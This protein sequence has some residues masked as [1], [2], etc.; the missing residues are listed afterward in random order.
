MTCLSFRNEAAPYYGALSDGD[1]STIRQEDHS[2]GGSSFSTTFREVRDEHH[3]PILEARSK[4]GVQDNAKKE[5]Q[6][7]PNG[8]AKRRN[9]KE[10]EYLRSE[11]KARTHAPLNGKHDGKRN[12]V[13]E[14]RNA[15]EERE[16]SGSGITAEA[17]EGGE[18]GEAPCGI[19]L[20]LSHQGASTRR[21]ISFQSDKREKKVEDR[22]RSK[23]TKRMSNSVN[24][25]KSVCEGT[26]SLSSSLL[27]VAMAFP[28]KR[29][30]KRMDSTPQGGMWSAPNSC[31]ERVMH[32]DIE[33]DVLS[34]DLLCEG[35][36][37]SSI[38]TDTQELLRLDPFG[39]SALEEMREEE[40]SG[41]AFSFSSE[42]TSCVS[43]LHH[44]ENVSSPP[45]EVEKAPSQMYVPTR[46]SRA[47]YRRRGRAWP[48]SCLFTIGDHHHCQHVVP[49]AYGEEKHED[50][51][52]EG[53]GSSAGKRHG[54]LR[55][56][57]TSA[58]RC[59]FPVPCL[60]RTCKS[61][62]DTGG[63]S[64]VEGDATAF[65]DLLVMTNKRSASDSHDAAT[66][67]VPAPPLRSCS[68][69][70]AGAPRRLSTCQEEEGMPM[71][72][73]P[74]SP[75]SAPHS[76]VL[77]LLLASRASVISIHVRTTPSM[78]EEQTSSSPL[79]TTLCPTTPEEISSTRAPPPT[80]TR[81][82]RTR[83]H[84]RGGRRKEST[85]ASRMDRT[86]HGTPLVPRAPLRWDVHDDE[87]TVFCHPPPL[88][89]S[90]TAIPSLH[91]AWDVSPVASSRSSPMPNARTEH[92]ASH[93]VFTSSS[94]PQET[95]LPLPTLRRS[96]TSPDPTTLTAMPPTSRCS[97]FSST[98]TAASFPCASLSSFGGS[99]HQEEPT[100]RS[101]L[102]SLLSSPD[103]ASMESI[104]QERPTSSPPLALPEEGE[105]KENE[106]ANTD[107]ALLPLNPAVRASSP[108]TVHPPLPC[109]HH[110]WGALSRAS[111][112]WES[113]MEWLAWEV[114]KEL[115]PLYPQL[116][117]ALL[118]A[119][120][121]EAAWRRR[122]RTTSQDH[123]WISSLRIGRTAA[124]ENWKRERSARST[125][126]GKHKGWVEEER[127][128]LLADSPVSTCC[129]SSGFCSMPYWE[130]GWISLSTCVDLTNR[131][132]HNNKPK[133]TDKEGLKEPVREAQERKQEEERG[134]ENGAGRAGED[135]KDAAQEEK[136]KDV[137]PFR[138]PDGPSG[139]S[140]EH[141]AREGRGEGGRK[142]RGLS[143]VEPNT[144]FSS[145]AC[146]EGK[147]FRRR[148]T[149][150][151]REGTEGP[152]FF[153]KHQ[154]PHHLAIEKSRRVWLTVPLCEYIIRCYGRPCV[155]LHT[156]DEAG[157]DSR[158]GKDAYFPIFLWPGGRSEEEEGKR[159]RRRI[160]EFLYSPSA[161]K[162]GE[163]EREERWRSHHHQP[164]LGVKNGILRERS[165]HPAAFI[166]VVEMST[167]LAAMR[168]AADHPPKEKV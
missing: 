42:A 2:C 17:R 97:S 67:L 47:P 121:E 139:V 140:F 166:P 98:G 111:L 91:G 48:T 27:S 167:F 130:D 26:P 138:L 36:L 132:L 78:V 100:L 29:C 85:W 129:G 155:A 104:T 93:P 20:R 72:S 66:P 133:P 77:H 65:A 115:L 12:S 101:R 56:P 153:E 102:V 136:K 40:R 147:A 95:C 168:T 125:E 126:A 163:K 137:E 84:V 11:N 141:L 19:P 154:K 79:S 9:K 60:K 46:P 64:V 73:H 76:S 57:R 86:V 146:G 75:S 83:R 144:L 156:R 94:S 33:K 119:A 81:E 3:A 44:E 5:I 15:K 69:S 113:Q 23:A 35:S 28:R 8:V 54:Y 32:H 112:H 82:K 117:S 24:S 89:L 110:W 25:Q 38:S 148:D 34:E 106:E 14:K 39:K 63:E 164:C 158:S 70:C 108:P 160:K 71:E 18:G 80:E 114:C 21:G 145:S 88:S 55:P 41:R 92:G 61:V 6:K 4:A 59:P 10:T 162:D 50:A 142:G 161:S 103:A 109:Q 127:S 22:S 131:V 118:A 150:Q 31:R 45:Q 123:L 13:Q 68:T 37:F 49:T 90:P 128:A 152:H 43:C 120:E 53:G 16:R 74:L 122:L 99:D 159:T 87:L 143:E 135:H 134:K 149:G 165:N 116:L 7:S 151:M 51:D 62:C 58:T 105:E 124:E 157:R 1:Y 96:R 30:Q 107:L 52:E